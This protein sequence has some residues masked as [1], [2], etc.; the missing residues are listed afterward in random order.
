MKYFNPLFD[1]GKHIA[2]HGYKAKCGKSALMCRIANAAEDSVALQ[3]DPEDTFFKY[4]SVIQKTLGK[5]QI[6][7]SVT[8]GSDISAF[9]Q[10]IYKGLPESDLIDTVYYICPALLEDIALG[11][12]DEPG[13]EFR[14][15]VLRAIQD[16]YPD[17]HVNF[18]QESD[19]RLKT[20]EMFF[21]EELDWMTI[22]EIERTFLKGT[23]LSELRLLLRDASLHELENIHSNN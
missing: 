8:P 3:H 16:M 19:A 17:A 15:K 9:S 5:S 7:K 18:V 13:R 1:N 14:A 23:E 22:R 2:V 11:V 12:I 20:N 6:I 10:V 4:Y 21:L